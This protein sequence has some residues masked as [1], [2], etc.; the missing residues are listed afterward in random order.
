MWLYINIINKKD[1][2]SS[3]TDILAERLF[4]L[5]YKKSVSIMETDWL[6][7]VD[8]EFQLIALIVCVEDNLVAILQLL[9]EQ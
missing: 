2:I 1:A 8:C 6:L 7:F 5:P 4:C 9:F 3:L